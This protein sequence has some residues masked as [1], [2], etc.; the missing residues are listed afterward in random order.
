MLLAFQ[1]SD[2]D[3]AIPHPVSLTEPVMFS[4]RGKGSLFSK[5][6]VRQQL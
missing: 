2:D 4:Y 1:A 3:T 6:T 5:K